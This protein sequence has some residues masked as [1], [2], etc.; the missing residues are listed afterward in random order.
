MIWL[1]NLTAIV[2]YAAVGYTVC[3]I[4]HRRP[5]TSPPPLPKRQPGAST[6]HGG[7]TLEVIHHPQAVRICHHLDGCITVYQRGELG[8]HDPSARCIHPTGDWDAAAAR[9]EQG[10]P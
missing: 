9:L 6:R 4:T 3:L 7:I 8:H 10:Q 2:V 1:L 5:R